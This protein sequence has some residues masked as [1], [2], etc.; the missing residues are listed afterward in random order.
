MK[1][2]VPLFYWKLLTNLTYSTKCKQEVYEMKMRIDDFLKQKLAL[3]DKNQTE[4]TCFQQSDVKTNLRRWSGIL[5]R[6][7]MGRLWHSHALQLL[8]A[9]YTHIYLYTLQCTKE[10]FNTIFEEFR[11]FW[12]QQN[13][14]LY[15]HWNLKFHR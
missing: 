8:P 6:C 10:W 3:V 12:R 2:P 15:L 7:A 5:I 13:R 14:I 4:L 11:L 1:L 9:Q